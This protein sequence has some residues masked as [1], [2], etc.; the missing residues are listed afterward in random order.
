MR[1]IHLGK[2]REMKKLSKFAVILAIGILAAALALVG[3][4]SGSSSS[5]ASASGSSASASA[6]SASA[7]ASASSASA[8]ASA[9]SASSAAA[10]DANGLGLQKDGVIVFATV[11][12]WPPFE[13]M[14]GTDEPEGF[15]IALAK[16][17][18][19]KLGLKAEFKSYGDFDAI[20]PAVQS[21][22]EVDAAISGISITPE[23]EELV[24]FSNSYYT[25]DLAIAAMKSSAM[26][27][28]KLDSADITIAVQ[29]GTT[30]NDYVKEN[31]PK[32]ECM[33]L[34]NSTD[35]FAAMQAGQAQ[36]VCTNKAVVEKMIA[37]SYSDAEVIKPIATDENFGI[38]V[39]KENAALRDAIN[40]A[41][42]QLVADGTVNKL[43]EQYL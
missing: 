3:C 34:S 22:T 24:A 38:A 19:E 23:R 31:Y 29:R 16:A 8:S 12:D 1:G 6:S 2:G 35:C 28:D 30:G 4:S 25:D 37:E 41:L 18:A 21:A 42:E 20:F 5:S 9:A 43:M 17:V 11:P 36:A 15:D 14:E 10:S 7:S 33:E 27:E 32:A 26:S 13:N 39:N 40:G